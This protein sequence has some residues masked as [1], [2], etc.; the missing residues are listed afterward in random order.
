MDKPSAGHHPFG[1][2]HDAEFTDTVEEALCLSQ[3]RL[4][5]KRHRLYPGEKTQNVLAVQNL[6]L[7]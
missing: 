1:G 2:W 5:F 3:Q 4:A 7:E 6:A